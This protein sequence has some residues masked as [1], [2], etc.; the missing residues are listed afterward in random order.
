MQMPGERA[1]ERMDSNRIF[2]IGDLWDISNL[3]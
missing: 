2:L 1:L 3:D